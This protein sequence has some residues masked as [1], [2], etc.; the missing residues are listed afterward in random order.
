MVA[1]Q[2]RPARFIGQRTDLRRAQPAQIEKREK[3]ENATDH[4]DFAFNN[5]DD[6]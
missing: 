4:L 1:L 5:H 3:K 2:R 6:R